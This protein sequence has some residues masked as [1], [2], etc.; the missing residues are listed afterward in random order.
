MLGGLLSSHQ[1]AAAAEDNERR[2]LRE[3]ERQEIDESNASNVDVIN[4]QEH[5]QYGSLLLDN[6]ANNT[7][8][9]IGERRQQQQQHDVYEEES[10]FEGEYSYTD[11]E[12]ESDAEYTEEGEEGEE[13]GDHSSSSYVINNNRRS[14][15][16]NRQDAEQQQEGGL[17][18][19]KRSILQCWHKIRIIV[20]AIADVDNVWDSP[21]SNG[22]RGTYVHVEDTRSTNSTTV[23]VNNN[24]QTSGI[25]YNVITGGTTSTQRNRTAAIIFW[26]IFLATSYASERSTFKLLVDRVGPFRLFS[27]ELILGAHAVF[28]GLCMLLGRLFRKEKKEYEMAENGGVVGFGLSGFPIADVGCKSSMV[29]VFDFF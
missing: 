28:T 24:H 3:Q 25:L 18:S 22:G 16:R 10:D 7:V 23:G 15:K 5:N 19:F 17:L 11:E 20:V 2:L 6:A 27:A 1:E 14:R 8:D 13:G 4:N 29:R 26:F 21:L 12:G 9:G